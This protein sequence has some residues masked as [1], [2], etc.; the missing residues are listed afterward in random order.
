MKAKPNISMKV[1]I[2]FTRI[3]IEAMTEI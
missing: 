2:N 3:F 1:V